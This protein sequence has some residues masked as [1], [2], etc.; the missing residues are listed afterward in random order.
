MCLNPN[1]QRNRNNWR[2][3]VL[4]NC[5]PNT[6]DVRSYPRPRQ[7]WRP[8]APSCPC[9]ASSTRR[10]TSGRGH[11]RWIRAPQTR[12]ALWWRRI[13]PHWWMEQMAP[14]ENKVR[15]AVWLQQKVSDCSTWALPG[16]IV[17]LH[18]QTELTAYNGSETPLEITLKIQD[19]WLYLSTECM[20]LTIS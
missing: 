2:L 12:S 11:L 5:A 10:C 6:A 1:L 15:N 16:S 3:S 7:H 20:L 19:F 14:L 9:P 8:C 13:S 4:M 18:W 17:P